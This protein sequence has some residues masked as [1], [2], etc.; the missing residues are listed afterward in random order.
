MIASLLGYF[1][2][3][4]FFAMEL[5][6]RR[7]GAARTLKAG[8]SD[9]GTTNLIGLSYGVGILLPPILNYF[10]IGAFPAAGRVGGLGV[11]LMLTGLG[12][13][14]WS[15]HALGRYYTRTLLISEEQSI[16]KEGPYR[17]IRHPGYFGTLLVMIGLAVAQANW[18]AT[19]LVAGLLMV[20]YHR[21]MNAEEAML[22]AAFG[23]LYRSY[24][25]HTWRL[26]PRV[27]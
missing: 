18:I 15:M 24:Q 16:I 25:E 2:L 17:I 3:V 1:L 23:D 13:R 8:L 26:L 5:F 27:Y 11:L 10:S 14:G 6:L 22:T 21:R 4:V 12:M 19:G 7:G 20:A 9:R